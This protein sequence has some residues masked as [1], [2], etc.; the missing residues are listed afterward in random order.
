MHKDLSDAK[1]DNAQIETI[2]LSVFIYIVFALGLGSDC[3]IRM[4]TAAQLKRM[5]IYPSLQNRSC[6]FNGYKSI[7]SVYPQ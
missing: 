2:I 1:P 5:G 7:S 3:I 6:L 4:Q